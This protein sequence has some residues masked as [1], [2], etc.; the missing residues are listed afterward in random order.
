[1]NEVRVSP[2]AK[3]FI[4]WNHVDGPMLVCTDG[5]VHWLS[6]LERV[7]LRAGLTTLEELDAKYRRY[8]DCKA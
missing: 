5:M 2:D 8:P 4:K 7:W 3:A 6:L 1:M